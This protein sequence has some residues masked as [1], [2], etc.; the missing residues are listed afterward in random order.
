MLVEFEYAGRLHEVRTTRAKV[1]DAHGEDEGDEED[2]AHSR[3]LALHGRSHSQVPH[4]MQCLHVRLQ[5]PMDTYGVEE[6]E[7][8]AGHH[9][10]E[11]GQE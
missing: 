10:C 3:R 5:R 9:E 4:S 2:D 8:E 11:A 6:V 1:R 7:V